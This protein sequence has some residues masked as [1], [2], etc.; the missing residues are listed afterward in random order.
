V[1]CRAGRDGRLDPRGPGGHE[2][3]GQRGVT[4]SSGLEKREGFLEHLAQHQHVPQA[5]AGQGVAAGRDRLAKTLHREVLIAELE[6]DEPQGAADPRPQ[7]WSLHC[8]TAAFERA[9]RFDEPSTAAMQGCQLDHRVTVS[10][11]ERQRPLPG[12]LGLLLFPPAQ[13]KGGQVVV[14]RRVVPVALDGLAVHLLGVGEA[15]QV[16]EDRAHAAPAVWGGRILFGHPAERFESLR[17]VAGI[18]GGPAAEEERTEGEA[19]IGPIGLELDRAPVV[20][21]GSLRLAARFDRPAV[22]DAREREVR[23]GCQRRLQK[24]IGFRVAPRDES[25]VALTEIPRI[26]LGAVTQD[27]LAD[28]PPAILGIG[29]VQFGQKPGI[30][31]AGSRS[32]LGDRGEQQTR[33]NREDEQCGGAHGHTAPLQRRVPAGDAAGRRVLATPTTAAE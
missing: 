20:G 30:V 32:A 11:V 21:G 8:A 25:F 29:A 9:D 31:G 15:P 10:P 2:G 23:P 26:G 7:R 27:L 22:K 14:E 17:Q 18:L 13:V 16:R 4:G 28:L 6:I 24:L 33:G 12:L 3:H 5:K 19:G 1:G